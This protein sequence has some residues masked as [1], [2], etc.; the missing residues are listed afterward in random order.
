M[1]TTRSIE[2]N[3]N[4]CAWKG[5]QALAQLPAPVRQPTQTIPDSAADSHDKKTTLSYIHG[6]GFLQSPSVV[7]NDAERNKHAVTTCIPGRSSDTQCWQHDDVEAEEA[8]LT[9]K[10]R[11]VNS[12][13]SARRTPGWRCRASSTA[14]TTAGP[15]CV[16]SSTTSSPAHRFEHFI[17]TEATAWISQ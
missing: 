9:W 14:R 16:C 13:G 5:A 6:T 15:P 12:P 2:C 3:V 11:C 1:S 4:M 10:A 17:S 8:V 7:L